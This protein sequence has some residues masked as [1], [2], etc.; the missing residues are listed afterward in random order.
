MAVPSSGT[1]F[2]RSIAVEL[3][4]DDYGVHPVD[5]TGL[6][7]LGATSLKDM[8]TGGGTNSSGSSLSGGEFDNINTNSKS[9]TGTVTTSAATNVSNNQFTMN[10]SISSYGGVNINTT[11]PYAMSEFYSYDHDATAPVK[12]FVYSSSNSFPERNG[13]GVSERTV[14]GTG[15]GSFS[16]TQFTGILSNTT[17]YYRSFIANN[18]G[19]AYGS[20]V[21]LTTTSGTSLTAYTLKYSSSKFGEDLVCN[22]TNTVTVYSSAAN[23]NAIFTGPTDIFANSSGGSDAANGWYS[24]GLYKG[25]WTTFGTNGFWSSGFISGCDE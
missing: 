2:L 13:S 9:T 21:S 22:T 10:G 23:I 20:V 18:K 5:G 6:S 19:V 7:Q 3:V 4:F 11:A 14:S 24:N 16:V 8:S 15:T 25:K 1:L 17:Y 12:G